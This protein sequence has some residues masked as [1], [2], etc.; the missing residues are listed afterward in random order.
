MILVYLKKIWDRMG[1]AWFISKA[2][3]YFVSL[4][5]SMQSWIFV[6]MYMCILVHTHEWWA[7]SKEEEVKLS[8]LK[9]KKYGLYLGLDRDILFTTLSSWP[10]ICL[11]KNQIIYYLTVSEL[12]LS[13]FGEDCQI[14]RSKLMVMIKNEKWKADTRKC[15]CKSHL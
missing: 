8:F 13:I 12:I 7:A 5:W 10:C 4:I 6:C 9:H 3:R 14:V 1:L 2:Q 11:K 15:E